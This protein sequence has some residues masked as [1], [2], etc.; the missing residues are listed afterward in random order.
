MR[1][2]C[3][4]CAAECLNAVVE[5]LNLMAYTRVPDCAE[6]DINTVSHI[7]LIMLRDV[8]NV[9]RVIEQRGFDTP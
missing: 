8:G 3:A 7:G 5:Y 2:V 1:P 6:N 9:F 4:I